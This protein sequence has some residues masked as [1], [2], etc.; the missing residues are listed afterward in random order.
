MNEYKFVYNEN[1]EDIGLIKNMEDNII[2]E[3]SIDAVCENTKSEIMN[4]DCVLYCT[5]CDFVCAFPSKYVDNEFFTKC[6]NIIDYYD[7]FLKDNIIHNFTNINCENCSNILNQ[8]KFTIE[9]IE[10]T[11]ENLNNLSMPTDFIKNIMVYDNNNNLIYSIEP[12]DYEEYKELI[13][14]N[15]DISKNLL[16]CSNCKYIILNNLKKINRYDL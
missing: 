11:Q 10:E 4:M 13:N 9:I 16:Y 5:N 6:D 8:G 1:N 3:I 12:S 14:F 15:T 2:K 7:N